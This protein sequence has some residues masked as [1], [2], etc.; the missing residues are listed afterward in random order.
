MSDKSKTPS[1]PNLFRLIT[2]DFIQASESIMTGF[3]THPKERV[4]KWLADEKMLMDQNKILQE[5]QPGT[6]M[7]PKFVF[8]INITLPGTPNHHF[9]M[10]WAI[11]DFASH[12]I[13]GQG[14]KKDV[15]PHSKLLD[16]F[17]FGPSDK[18]RNKVLKVIPR[19]IEGNVFLKAVIGS[20]P[21]LLGKQLKPTYI[22]SDRFLE[23][24]IDVSSSRSAMTETLVKK[25]RSSKS[26]IVAEFGFVLEGNDESVLPENILGSIR[27][28]S[29]DFDGKFRLVD[30]A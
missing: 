19:I 21:L 25:A 10:Y 5:R 22:R 17:F 23:V 30:C 2:V 14:S 26:K 8:C 1:S 6:H 9:I 7:M 27:L 18:F 16:D 28:Q 3:C 24:I 20:S 11:D 13:R 29:S 12:G 15:K 4:Q